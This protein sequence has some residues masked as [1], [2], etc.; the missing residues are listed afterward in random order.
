MTVITQ[1]VSREIPAVIIHENEVVIAFLDRDPINK[2]HVLIC[3]KVHY[4]DFLDVPEPI[5]HELMAV[6]RM[7]YSRILMRY[8]PDGISFIQ[9]NG[10]YNELN[11]FH[12]HIFPRHKGDCFGWTCSEIGLQTMAQLEIEAKNFK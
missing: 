12:I 8:E 9:N 1:I 3:P 7:I 6:A 5:M 4:R 11:H 2:G 10:S